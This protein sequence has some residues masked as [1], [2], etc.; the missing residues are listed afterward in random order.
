MTSPILSVIE[1][2]TRWAT[3]NGF[4]TKNAYVMSLAN[5]LRQEMSSEALRDFERASGRELR[6]RGIR[7]PRMQ[8]LRSSSALSVNVFDYWRNRDPRPLQR[9]FGLRDRITKVTFEKS[10]PT[11]LNTNPPNVDVMLTLEGNRHIAIDSKFTEWLTPRDRTI[12]ERY[13][14]DDSKLLW[15]S[16]KLPRC[17]SLA[18]RFR[19]S[20]PFKFLDAPQLL[21]HALGIGQTKRGRHELWYMYFDWNCPESEVHAMELRR[22]SSLVGSEIRFRAMT[23]QELFKRLARTVTPRDA[24]YM[25]YLTG[26]YTEA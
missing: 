4:E 9:A 14:A 6:Q 18:L 19:D 26:R 13:F 1:Q 24:A 10:F 22:F 11:G 3:N 7:P 16:A 21:K 20:T 2:Q 17:Q 23:Y 12:D 15:S 8:A 25:D 5:N